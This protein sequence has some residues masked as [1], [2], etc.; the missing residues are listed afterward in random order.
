[1]KI[2][3]NVPL[4]PY[5][6][7]HIGGSAAFFCEVTTEDELVEA[8][9]FAGEN[10]LPVT[11]LGGGSNVL[12]SD[13]GVAGLLIHM[14]IQGISY[15][16]TTVH[17]G[18][19]VVFDELIQ[20][21]VAH[22][23]WGIENL[24]AIP[25]TVG[26]SVVQNIG[27]YGVEVDQSVHSVRVYDMHEKK[28]ST[29]TNA[30]CTFSYRDSFFKCEGK[31]RYIVTQVTFSLTKKSSPQ[32]TYKD[33]AQYFEGSKIPTIQD[34][35]TAIISIRAGKFP[36]TN[37]IG[38]AGSFFKNPVLTDD[39]YVR[40]CLKYPLLPCYFYGNGVKIPLAWIL[41]NVL[42]LRGFRSGNIGAYE[43]QPLVFVNYANG[44]AEEVNAFADMIAQ[45]VFT[46]TSI[47]IEREVQ[48]IS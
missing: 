9:Q 34:V 28:L 41:D 21:V 3:K 14:C 44:T 11:V 30:Q 2:E 10:N 45:K 4:A 6:T 42:S 31:G 16:D 23:L 22:G 29:V 37:V 12:V 36:D 48:S 20:D 46:A 32:V 35:R 38:T 7:F 43:K 15:E 27:A 33:L 18:A 5:T 26:A 39:E 19:G 40:L 47:H 17:A 25:G 1:M 8:V 24:S 13:D